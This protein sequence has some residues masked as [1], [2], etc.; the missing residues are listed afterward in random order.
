MIHK[1][2]GLRRR[3]FPFGKRLQVN[4]SIS[5][6]LPTCSAFSQMKEAAN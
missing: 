3:A 6:S 1:P 5:G 2:A 4:S